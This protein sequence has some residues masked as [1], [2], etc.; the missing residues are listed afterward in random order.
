MLTLGGSSRILPVQELK[1]VVGSAIPS[2]VKETGDKVLTNQ[3]TC[4]NLLLHAALSGRSIIHPRNLLHLEA[5]QT[6]TMPP[7]PRS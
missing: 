3:G 6:L 7:V 1:I 2:V 5:P 4:A